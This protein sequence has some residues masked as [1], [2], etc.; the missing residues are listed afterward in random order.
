[1]VDK[2]TRR[3]AYESLK[4]LI[5]YIEGEDFRGYDPYDALNSPFLKFLSFNS[6]Y[7]GIIFTQT[8]KR[9]PLNPRPL[10]GIKKELNPKALGLFLWGYSKLYAVEKKEE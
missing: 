10:L 9:S 8:I 1:M 3:I 2:G 4:K 5:N 7:P 6:K